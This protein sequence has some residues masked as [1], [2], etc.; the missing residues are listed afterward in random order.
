MEK[1]VYWI[2]SKFLTK[3]LKKFF[4]QFIF[5]KSILYGK[6]FPQFQRHGAFQD[7]LKSLLSSLIQFKNRIKYTLSGIC[8]LF[9]AVHFAYSRCIHKILL[10]SMNLRISLRLPDHYPL[11]NPSCVLV[12]PVTTLCLIEHQNRSQIICF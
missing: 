8:R 6:R 7:D 3:R 4:L 9:P 1:N 12:S 5:L 2:S 11:P 10:K